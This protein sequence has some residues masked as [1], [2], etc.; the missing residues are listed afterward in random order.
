[1]ETFLGSKVAVNTNSGKK[2]THPVV[3]TSLKVITML[4]KFEKETPS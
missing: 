1:L 3:S 4:A 2:A